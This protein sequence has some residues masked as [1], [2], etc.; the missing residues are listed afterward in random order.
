[1]S[2]ATVAPDSD[3]P[4]LAPRCVVAKLG[5]GRARGDREPLAERTER[6]FDLA[7]M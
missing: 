5:L 4:A 2:Y 1:M 3:S 6:R 7:D